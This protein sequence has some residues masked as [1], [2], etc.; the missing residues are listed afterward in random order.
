VLGANW[1]AMGWVYNAGGYPTFGQCYLDT[2]NSFFLGQNSS[3]FGFMTYASGAWQSGWY[4][5]TTPPS[6]GWHKYVFGQTGSSSGFL[7]IDGSVK[8]LTQYYSG[9]MGNSTLN[10]TPFTTGQYS[11]TTYPTQ[12]IDEFAIWSANQGSAIPTAAMLNA[13]STRRLIV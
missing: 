11:T 8:S 12:Y 13:F 6:S 9:T 5:S 10:S 2:N 4:I 1:I 7:Y 3:Q